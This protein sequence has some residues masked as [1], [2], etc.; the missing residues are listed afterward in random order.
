MNKMLEGL[1]GA[2]SGKGFEG[3]TITALVI[4][5]TV[6]LNV[7]IYTLTSLFGWY[8]YSP[9]SADLSLSGSTDELF[10][11]AIED[12]EEVTVMFCLTEDALKSHDTG[13]YVLETARG[14]AERYPDFV[15]LK[16]VNYLT[17]R[18]EDGKLVDLAKYKTDMR[19]NEI[20]IYDSSVIFISGENY[21]VLTDVYTAAGFA[22]F[23]TLNSKYEVEAYNGE[24]VMASMISWVLKDDSEHKTAYFT[25][26]HGE[27]VDVAF[28]NM[29]SCAGYYVNVV[30][31]RKQPVPEDAGLVVISNPRN[32]FERAALEGS[33]VRTE[34]ERLEAYLA[35]G[36]GG[37]GGSLY[38]SLDPYT[39]RLPVLEGF[40]FEHGITVEG[41]DGEFGYSR[42]L[43]KDDT[44]G[45]SLDGLS[46]LASYAEGEKATLIAESAK[47]AN[48]AS[49]LL[50]RTA[51]LTLSNGAKALLYSSPTSVA[52]NSDEVVD[53]EGGYA[54]VAYSDTTY[55]GGGTGRI[56]VMPSVLTT[57]TDTLITK[58]YANKDFMYSVFEVLF[59]SLTSPRGANVVLYNTKMLE[60]LPMGLS[61]TV[62]VCLMI[63][64]AA[65]AVV[66]Y[67]T[68]KRRANR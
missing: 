8:I 22:D 53:S 60:N 47:G 64:P 49:V 59:D 50:A 20:A 3:N 4:A 32:D 55:D 68:L 67:V 5:V 44:N 46:I 62:F 11:E 41:R 58:G 36:N 42:D 15:K 9:E 7:L 6:V 17:R 24:E 52:M 26:N 40:L 16:F 37:L 43:V 35:E 66:G 19:G 14:F 21:K 1:K 2:F 33:G 56:V 34:I 12:G 10:A 39:R 51:R 31:L 28:S 57:T 65:L 54:V 25:E 29:L 18:D 13:A 27:T 61:R 48:S 23:Y 38:V 30:N 45:I 63:I